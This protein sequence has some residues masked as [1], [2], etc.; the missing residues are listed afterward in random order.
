[1]K[2]LLVTDILGDDG[3]V[4]G[5]EF[6]DSTEINLI[7]GNILKVADGNQCVLLNVD[8]F[9]SVVLRPV[10]QEDE[11]FDCDGACKNRCY[12]CA[13]QDRVIKGDDTGVAHH[14]V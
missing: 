7:G 6:A 5:N 14:P 13:Q 9:S 3:A 1:M 11:Q 8:S 12:D 4:I 2:Q 10:E